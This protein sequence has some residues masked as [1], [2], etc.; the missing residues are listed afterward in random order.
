MIF[1]SHGPG[2]GQ[3]R[4]IYSIIDLNTIKIMNFQISSKQV[5]DEFN[6]KWYANVVLL[7]KKAKIYLAAGGKA[8]RLLLVI[9]NL[10]DIT[11]FYQN[12][13]KHLPPLSKT[14]LYATDHI[15]LLQ[16]QRLVNPALPASVMITSA[17]PLFK[18]F[19]LRAWFCSYTFLNSVL[20]KTKKW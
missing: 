5:V 16:A 19:L 4:I 17:Y 15:N 9:S 10:A 6:Q 12:F 2:C 20:L 11:K 13:R 3:S 8:P 18:N 14:P 7:I 1:K